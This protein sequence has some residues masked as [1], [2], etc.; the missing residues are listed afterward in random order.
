MDIEQNDSNRDVIFAVPAHASHDGEHRSRETSQGDNFTDILRA[1]F[2]HSKMLFEALQA[3][4]II[5]DTF[6]WVPK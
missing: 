5:R 1:P 3:V 6:F 2:F 4:Q